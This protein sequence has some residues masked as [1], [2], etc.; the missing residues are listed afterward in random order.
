MNYKLRDSN[1]ELLRIICMIMII[2]LHTQSHGGALAK[3]NLGS[4]EF[5][6]SNLIESF[7]IVAVNCYILISGF[8]GIDSKF[9]IKKF[10]KLYSQMFFYSII[11]STI[12]WISDKSMLSIYGILQ[13]VF[14]LNMKIWWFMSVFLILYLFTP[15]I[16]K[17]LKTLNKREINLLI[18]I[19]MLVIVIFP[20][21]PFFNSIILDGGYSLCYFILLYIVGAYIKIFFKDSIFNKK[22]FFMIYIFCCII[23]CALNIGISIICGHQNGIYSYNFI[24]IFISSISLFIFFKELNI[25]SRFINRLSTLTLGVYLISD[26]PYVRDW[27]YNY[28]GYDNYFNKS[29]FFLYTIY[30]IFLIYIITSIIEYIRQ[31][32]FKNIE[33]INFLKKIKCK[34]F[35]CFNNTILNIIKDITNVFYK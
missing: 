5:L 12:F 9:K 23:L 25:K 1:F 18:L 29:S 17:L 2:A 13:A 32:I 14:P 15:Y 10:L 6:I 30:I 19:L 28:L 11:I 3:N 24:L 33:K 8:F 31:N 22:I 26:H 35:Y 21:I 20:S 34:N 27:I 16:N 7:S 4:F